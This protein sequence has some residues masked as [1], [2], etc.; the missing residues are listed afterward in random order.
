LVPGHVTILIKGK[1]RS[2]KGVSIHY[3]LDRAG[4]V[5]IYVLKA[6]PGNHWKTIAVLGTT[7]AH[8][9]GNQLTFNGR[10]GNK[11]LAPGTYEVVAGAFNNG[12]W[13]SPHYAK[14]TVVQRTVKPKPKKHKP[15]H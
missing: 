14:L 6:L 7:H 5:A 11:L 9:G 12:A 4:G 15:K 10:S 8:A 3:S 2:T 13:S 1:S